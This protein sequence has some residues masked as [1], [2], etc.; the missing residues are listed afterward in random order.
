MGLLL[1]VKGWL[2]G[3]LTDSCRAMFLWP[4][5]VQHDTRKKSA[6]VFWWPSDRTV[7]LSA[8]PVKA[9]AVSGGSISSLCT[10]HTLVWLC[11]SNFGLYRGALSY[12]LGQQGVFLED[13]S[14][15]SVFPKQHL[16]SVFWTFLWFLCLW[17]MPSS[18]LAV[19]NRTVIHHKKIRALFSV[20]KMSA[21]TW[22]SFFFLLA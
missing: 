18:N 9:L 22:S 1:K 21:F 10:Y 8:Y 5:V 16:L 14:G 6:C 3:L 20:L 4:W 12:Q 15:A 11:L 2:E 17:S 7:A 13:P 19:I